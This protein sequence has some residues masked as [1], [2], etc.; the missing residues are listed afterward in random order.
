MSAALVHGRSRVAPLCSYGG[1]EIRQRVE[2][3]ELFGIETCNRYDIFSLDG[4]RILHAAERD[5]GF[6][7]GVATQYVGHTLRTFRIDVTDMTGRVVLRILHHPRLF[8][9]R[10][11]VYTG[12]GRMLGSFEQCFT[13]FDKKLVVNGPDG[14]ARFTMDSWLLTPWDFAFKRA[15]PRRPRRV[16]MI[17]K[18]WSG[19]GRELFTDADTFRL[20]FE[21]RSLDA[22]E[23]ALLLAAVLFIDLV[24]FE[25]LAR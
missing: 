24:W 6:W 21:S 25:T 18:N 9:Q 14:R 1:L 7:D 5:G 3:A 10:I 23:R 8:L 19:L 17:R 11:E 4:R 20:D 2:P 13:W 15:A 12:H 16:A 22:D